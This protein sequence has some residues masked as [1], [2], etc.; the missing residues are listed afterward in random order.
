MANI[1]N[2]DNFIQSTLKITASEEL[3]IQK[4]LETEN[5]SNK[6]IDELLAEDNESEKK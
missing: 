4:D 2:I 1:E 5:E 6:S 3:D